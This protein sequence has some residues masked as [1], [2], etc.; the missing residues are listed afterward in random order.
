MHLT[1]QFH[2]AGF[3]GT[4]ERLRLRDPGLKIAVVE[5]IEVDD[6][7]APAFGAEQR[8]EATALQ[9]VY[10]LP[11]SFAP[12]E[13]TSQWVGGMNAKHRAHPCKY[14]PPDAATR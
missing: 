9:L 4:V 11:E 13:D 10:P 6:P 12:N 5:A 7:R 14:S 8:G 2:A 1:G 3:L